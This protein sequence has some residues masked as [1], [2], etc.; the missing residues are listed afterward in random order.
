MNDPFKQHNGGFS[1]H[2]NPLAANEDFSGSRTV[3]SKAYSLAYEP[4]ILPQNNPLA[5]SPT[6]PQRPGP[7][8][9]GIK[10]TAHKQPSPQLQ[11][12]P[13]I[14][15]IQPP[16][17]PPVQPPVQI[18]ITQPTYTYPNWAPNP[19]A[20]LRNRA[21]SENSPLAHLD[22]PPNLPVIDNSSRYVNAHVPNLNRAPNAAPVFA[23]NGIK[24]RHS[25]N[26]GGMPMWSDPND[27][28]LPDIEKE[29]V[30]QNLYKTELCRSYE[31][32]GSCRYGT[33]C[34]FAHGLAE[35]R[36]VLRHPKYKTE[37]CKSYINTGSCPYGSRCRF[38]HRH[39]VNEIPTNSLFLPLPPTA[40]NPK[41]SLWDVVQ[42][43]REQGSYVSSS[44]I[45]IAVDETGG[46]SE[47]SGEGGEEVE[48][49][50]WEG[51]GIE[52]ILEFLNL[53]DK[54]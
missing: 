33:K 34:Q 40:P 15:P 14:Q 23:P 21:T 10:P 37:V 3:I 18:P 45:D 52:K 16:I 43:K 42:K 6:S 31:D 46:E 38:I 29:L 17:Q 27:K 51:M 13:I 44:V 26:D 8:P 32:T 28:K 53:N 12:S 39:H 36:P 2:V 5:A 35:L 30:A 49:L 41:G 11:S 54:K 4:S 1:T 7:R 22:A 25:E 48:E 47:E 50:N 19:L 20:P 9:K 24:R